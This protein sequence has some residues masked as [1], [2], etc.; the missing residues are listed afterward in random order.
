MRFVEED[1]TAVVPRDRLVEKG[2]D[3]LWDVLWTY[4]KRYKAS[5]IMSGNFCVP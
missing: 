1:A 3:D 2:V 5:Y 4:K